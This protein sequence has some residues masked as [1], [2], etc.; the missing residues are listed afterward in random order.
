MKLIQH[1]FVLLV[2]AVTL[3]GCG[4][5]KEGGVFG[6]TQGPKKPSQY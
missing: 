1:L 3:A 4:D 6:N 5:S 2:L